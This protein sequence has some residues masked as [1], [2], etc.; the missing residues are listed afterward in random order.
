M[1]LDRSFRNTEDFRR[2]AFTEAHKEL[3]LHHRQGLTTKERKE[4]KGKNYDKRSLAIREIR[5]VGTVED[6]AK[7]GCID[8][9]FCALCVLCG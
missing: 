1:T 5:V 9:S 7:R 4:L 8:S 3:E 2:F 6:A